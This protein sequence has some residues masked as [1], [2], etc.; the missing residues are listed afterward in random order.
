MEKTILVVDDEVN[1]RDV[2]S[3]ALSRQGYNVLTV[4]TAADARE[5]VLKEK[6]DLVLLDINM[7]EVDG[8]ILFEVIRLFH[9]QVKV[10]ICSVYSIEEQREMV[11][12]ADGYFDKSEGIGVLINKVNGYMKNTNQHKRIVVIDD[13]QKARIMFKHVLEK[14]GYETVSFSDNEAA[15]QFFRNKDNHVDLVILD[16][17]MPNINGCS[18][19]EM[20]KMKHPDAKILIASNYPIDTQK[21]WIFNAEDYFDKSGGNSALLKKVE[22]LVSVEPMHNKNVG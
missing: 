2:Y 15:L 5:I 22:N 20:V 7:S 9:K 8:A 12:E 10:I 1:I 11:K 13:E 4:S 19:F 21:T 14:A 6:V 18:F 16:L 3:K 17:A